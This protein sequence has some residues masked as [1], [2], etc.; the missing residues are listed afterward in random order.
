MHQTMGVGRGLVDEVL[1][2]KLK[3]CEFK[4]HT[5][6]YICTGHSCFSRNFGDSMYMYPA[7]PVLKGDT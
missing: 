7:L 2:S 4:P 6:P 3:G 5:G 1:D